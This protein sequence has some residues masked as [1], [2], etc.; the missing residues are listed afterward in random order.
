MLVRDKQA[1]AEEADARIAQVRGLFMI[2]C[3]VVT[4]ATMQAAVEGNARIAQAR[5]QSRL[6]VPG[7]RAW[8]DVW[9]APCVTGAPAVAVVA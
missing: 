3:Q 1:A 4:R 9:A 5:G 8:R 2:L 6:F 7:L